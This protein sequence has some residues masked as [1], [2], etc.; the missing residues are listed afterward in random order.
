MSTIRQQPPGIRGQRVARTVVR[1][2]GVVV[3]LVTAVT[4]LVESW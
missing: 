3:V 1:V 4:Y 2:V